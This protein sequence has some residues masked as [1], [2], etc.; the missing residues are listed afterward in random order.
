MVKMKMKKNTTTTII[1]IT[2][3]SWNVFRYFLVQY[4]F[5]SLPNLACFFYMRKFFFLMMIILTHQWGK[6]KINLNILWWKHHRW[7]SDGNQKKIFFCSI[8]LIYY[9]TLSWWW[10]W[11]TYTSYSDDTIRWLKL[12][13]QLKKWKRKKFETIFKKKKKNLQIARYLN[14]IIIID[15]LISVTKIHDDEKKRM[16]T[17]DIK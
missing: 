14:R 5:F 4:F 16:K 7:E 6:V 8:S 12:I 13:S 11:W 2:T 15:R 9:Q 17:I 3:R 1:I 10:W